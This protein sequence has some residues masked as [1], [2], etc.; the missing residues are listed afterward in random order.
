MKD[1]INVAVVN[2]KSSGKKATNLSKILE[3]SEVASKRGADLL[4]F[5]ELCLT[6]YDF[7]VNA[8][9]STD[10]KIRKS[11]TLGGNTCKTIAEAAK[12]LG[13]YIVFG[14]GE[15]EGEESDILYNSAVVC[16]PDGLVGSYRKIHPFAEENKCFNKGTEPFLFDTPWGPVSVGICYDT[17]QFPE[18]LRYYVWKG[19]RLYLNLTALIEEI[20]KEGSR[21]AFLNYYGPTLEYG[22]LC[23]TVF[24]ASANLTGFDDFNYFGGGSA[25]LGP[26]V[27]QFFETDVAYY[28]GSKDNLKEGIYIA[29]VSLSLARR[30]LCIN[31][32][33]TGVPDYRPELYAK[34]K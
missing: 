25:V 17:Y 22:V 27:T 11:E 15:R 23:N 16:G 13:M 2:F 30:R 6:G 24:I 19:S 8:S 34:F 1:I 31:N 20:P 9:I 12:N 4:L 14:M 32:E 18:L 28:A 7:Y 29:T 3:F 10:E 26:K 5:P 33:Y 21:Q